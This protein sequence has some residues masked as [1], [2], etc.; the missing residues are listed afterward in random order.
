MRKLTKKQI[1]ILDSFKHIANVNDLPYEVWELLE[2]IN[3]TEVLYYKVNNYLQ[4]NHNY[5]T[6]E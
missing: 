1:D 2:Q 4:K 6:N 3:N 5:K